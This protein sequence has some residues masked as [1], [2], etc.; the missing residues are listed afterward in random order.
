M[1]SKTALRVLILIATLFAMASIGGALLVAYPVLLPLHIW[2]SY[3]QSGG[4]VAGWIA[5]SSLASAEWGWQ[6]AYILQGEN[7]SLIW[8]LPFLC[9]ILA[10]GVLLMAR[11]LRANQPA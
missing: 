6:L 5:L 10:V 3:N 2:A 11:R 1:N 9:A 4:M 8:I 7:G